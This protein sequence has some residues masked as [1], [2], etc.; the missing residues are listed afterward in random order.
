ML[1]VGLGLC[2]RDP[3]SRNERE[4]DVGSAAPLRKAQPQESDLVGTQAPAG[5]AEGTTGRERRAFGQ[6]GDGDYAVRRQCVGRVDAN[7]KLDPF[8]GIGLDAGGRG[9]SDLWKPRGVLGLG[10]TVLIEAC[11]TRPF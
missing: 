7:G 3:V 2:Q 10:R 8:S 4:L 11:G 1:E 5:H 6:G 9:E